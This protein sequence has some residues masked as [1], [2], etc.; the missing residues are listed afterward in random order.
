MLENI[1][2]GLLGLVLV[3]SSYGVY[4]ISTVKTEMQTLKDEMSAKM[5][6]I[7]AFSANTS[8]NSAQNNQSAMPSQDILPSTE[9]VVSGPTTSI[10]FDEEIHSFG[11]VQSC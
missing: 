3:V 7:N 11:T 9:S 6:A 10:K 8:G 4:Q 1:K 5:T 2:I